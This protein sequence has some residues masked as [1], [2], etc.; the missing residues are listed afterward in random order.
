MSEK[1]PMER[2]NYDVVVIGAGGAGSPAPGSGCSA[3]GSDTFIGDSAPTA[4]FTAKG[5]GRGQ[6][7]T[8]GLPD[9]PGGSGGGG[10]TITQTLSGLSD[11]NI[12]GPTSGQALVY[13]TTAA[14]WENKSF[15]SLI[16]KK[17]GISI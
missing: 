3:A 15:I 13:D 5:G 12:S 10:S 4:V 9:A 16:S 6:A 11:V 7:G 2:H 17:Y 14:K 1:I 8:A